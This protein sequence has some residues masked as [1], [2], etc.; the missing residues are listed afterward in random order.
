MVRLTIY[1]NYNQDPDL[2]IIYHNYSEYH[3]SQSPGER[4]V[5]Q[6]FERSALQ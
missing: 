6:W 2:T 5:A 4:D 1:H 3:E